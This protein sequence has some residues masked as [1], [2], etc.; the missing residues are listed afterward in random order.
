MLVATSSGHIGNSKI[1]SSLAL[2][3]KSPGQS[4]KSGTTKSGCKRKTPNQDNKLTFHS[5]RSLKTNQSADV[6]MTLTDA[7]LNGN[8]KERFLRI[9]RPDAGQS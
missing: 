8:G 5:K 4:L 6:R 9:R 1:V 3:P 2:S 7:R